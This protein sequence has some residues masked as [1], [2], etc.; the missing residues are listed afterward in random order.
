MSAVG[1]AASS[2]QNLSCIVQRADACAGTEYIQSDLL[3]QLQ[4]ATDDAV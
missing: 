3:V 4:A 1:G 2:T